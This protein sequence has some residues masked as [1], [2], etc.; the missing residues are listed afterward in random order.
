MPSR[1]ANSPLARARRGGAAGDRAGAVARRGAV[2]L[3]DLARHPRPSSRARVS[4]P[5]RLPRR[6]ALADL[7]WPTCRRAARQRTTRIGRP[8][9]LRHRGGRRYGDRRGQY[10]N[11]RAD[12]QASVKVLADWTVLDEI[13]LA[14]MVKLAANPPKVE[15]ILWCG[16]LTEYDETYDRLTSRNEK[17]LRR[18]ENREFYYVTTTDDPVIEKLAVQ[19]VGTVYATDH[20]LAHLMASPRS[21]YPWDIVVQKLGD[22]ARAYWVSLVARRS[23]LVARRS[24]LAAGRE[25]VS[26]ESRRRDARVRSSG[27]RKRHGRAE[28]RRS[29]SVGRRWQGRRGTGACVQALRCILYALTS[30]VDLCP[31][32]NGCRTTRDDAPSR[33]STGRRWF[34]GFVVD[35]WRRSSDL[36]SLSQAPTH[37]PRA[38]FRARR[39]HLSLAR[40]G[41]A[42]RDGSSSSTSATRLSSTTSRSRRR[43]T[44]RRSRRRTRR[45]S[46]R[47]SGSRSR[48]R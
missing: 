47:R 38:T 39:R 45:I 4:P 41:S 20:I 3:V 32:D 14:A 37:R 30:E 42:R 46:T 23:S 6:A 22:K 10:Q 19:G 12:R 36:S 33:V 7:P 24:S 9:T 28:S 35:E 29:G 17:P 34:D 15:D 21:V 16:A 11:Q 18:I 1:R 5:P 25:G 44:I 27:A 13:D 8:A 2:I 31:R 48:R 40:L 43:R 26:N